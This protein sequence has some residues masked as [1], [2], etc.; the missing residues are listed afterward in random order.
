[1][2]Q[3]QA[4]I[5]ETADHKESMHGHHKELT[6]KWAAIGDWVYG[7]HLDRGSGASSWDWSQPNCLQS[8]RHAPKSSLS[9]PSPPIDWSLA[10]F[11][12]SGAWLLGHGGQGRCPSLLIVIVLGHT[13]K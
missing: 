3:F 5:M 6:A 12:F 10:P 4:E 11:I 13:S 7:P 8:D 2:E 9:F 1:M